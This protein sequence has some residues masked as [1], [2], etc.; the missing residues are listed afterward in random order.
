M[1]TPNVPCSFPLD[2]LKDLPEE[3]RELVLCIISKEPVDQFLK[4][5]HIHASPNT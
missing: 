1:K 2:N 3:L 4:I 5:L